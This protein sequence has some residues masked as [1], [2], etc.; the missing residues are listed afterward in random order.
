MASQAATSR[1]AERI[2]EPLFLDG[3]I[4]HEV[5]QP[6]LPCHAIVGRPGRRRVGEVC[7]EVAQSVAR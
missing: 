4:E 5:G 2:V 7:R 1:A 6:A 3:G